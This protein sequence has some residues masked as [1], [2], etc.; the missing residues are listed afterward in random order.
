MSNHQ[1]KA[2]K[3]LRVNITELMTPKDVQPGTVLRHKEGWHTVATSTVDKNNGV[4]H[5]S[6]YGPIATFGILGSPIQPHHYL[7][8]L[9]EH[10]DGLWT[11]QYSGSGEIEYVDMKH[12]NTPK[13]MNK[14]MILNHQNFFKRFC[15]ALNLQ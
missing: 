8:A 13:F 15:E 5:E 6:G 14:Y 12:Y 4:S 3:F 11:M 2:E 7:K 1:E 9:S 10:T